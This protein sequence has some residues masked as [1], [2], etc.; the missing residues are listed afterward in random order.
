M[1]P[2]Q[3]PAELW[4]LVIQSLDRRPER[5]LWLLSVCRGMF[6]VLEPLMRQRH[7]E[8]E[9]R[10][11]YA[12]LQHERS[13]T[14]WEDVLAKDC[15]FRDERG[16]VKPLFE[17]PRRLLHTRKP[18]DWGPPLVWN[19]PVWSRSDPESPALLRALRQPDQEWHWRAAY[20]DVVQQY[21]PI[22]A[23]SCV[24]GDTRLLSII[25]QPLRGGDYEHVML[26]CGTDRWPLLWCP[27]GTFGERCDT[28]QVSLAMAQFQQ[29]MECVLPVLY[30]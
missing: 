25:W 26:H 27:G 13:I 1:E 21:E 17:H 23:G 10:R 8:C 14:E 11:P 2:V 15:F 12:T 9:E 30:L 16:C 28:I 20:W 22:T 3:L 4:H 29:Q 7:K 6:A 18:Y 19:L 5:S 24:M